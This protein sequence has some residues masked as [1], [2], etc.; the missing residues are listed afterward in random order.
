[1]VTSRPPQYFDKQG[2][3]TIERRGL[4]RDLR[5]NLAKDAYHFLRTASWTRLLLFMATLWIAVN[6]FFAAILF[7]GDASIQNAAPG[8]FL[9]RFWFSVQTMATIGY[10][11]MVPM[12]PLA[13]AVVTIESFV[14]ILITAMAT[15]LFF[16]KFSTPNAKVLFSK[17]AVIAPHEG[18]R[19]LMIRMANGRETAIVEANAHLTMTR[20]EILGD[21]S[22]FR[23]VHDLRLRRSTSPVFAL[24]WTIFHVIDEESPLHGV[25][26]DELEGSLASILVTFTGIDESLATPVHTRSS[27]QFDDL[28]FDQDFVD[29]L[30][31]DARGRYIDFASFHRTRPVAPAATAS[32]A[33]PA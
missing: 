7:F 20:D 2:R 29:I 1:M 23:R 13:H 30:G 22:R 33:D 28:R 32:S 15:G 6:L 25:T 11:Y 19:A 18:Q 21:G 4:P 16:A 24:S 5:G 10:G 12:D 27:Y 8:S 14:G 9:D 31:E 26:A 17:V 3:A